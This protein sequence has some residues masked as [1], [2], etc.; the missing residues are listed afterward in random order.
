MT[1]PRS[2]HTATLLQNGKVLIAGGGIGGGVYTSSAE[3]YDPA[4]GTFTATGSLA[5][6]RLAH[7][8]QLVAGGKVLVAGGWKPSRSF[9]PRAPSFTILRRAR[10]ASPH[11]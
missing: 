8:A 1:V 5:G 4:T 7:V 6:P 9:R 2:R 10:S 11:A 3:L